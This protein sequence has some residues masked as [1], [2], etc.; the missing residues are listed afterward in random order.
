MQAVSP[1]GAQI[2]YLKSERNSSS[3]A[4]EV[5]PAAGGPGREVVRLSPWTGTSIYASVAWTPDGRSLLFKRATKGDSDTTLY[6]VPVEGGAPEKLISVAGNYR[7]NY[8]Q[9]SPDGRRLAVSTWDGSALGE[10][11]TLENFLPAEMH[12]KRP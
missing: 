12:Q 9:V 10:I 7:L 5:R 3:V 1:D 2:A 11:W 4:L 6:R 8:P